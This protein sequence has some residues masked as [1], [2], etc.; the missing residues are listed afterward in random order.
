VTS[1]IEVPSEARL[2]ADDRGTVIDLFL[3]NARD[4]GSVTA[5][6]DGST[7]VTWRQYEE[8][9]SAVALALRDLGVT[10]GDVVGLHMVNRA[11]HAIADMGALLAGATP[12]SFYYTLAPEQL[13]YVASV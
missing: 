12:T 8:Q 3:R 5:I 9:A 6:V 11:E 1:N 4:H 2:P 13:A 10:K 7:R